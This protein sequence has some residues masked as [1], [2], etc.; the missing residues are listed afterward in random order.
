VDVPAPETVLHATC[1]ADAEGRGL[2]IL[3]PSGSGKSGLALRMMAL[4]ARLVADDRTII[5]DAGDHVEASCPAA[6][7][8]LI[9][10]RGVG[11]LR[12]Q[13]LRSARVV[14]AVDLA[15]RETVRLPE[16]RRIVFLGHEVDLVHGPVTAHFPAAL[17]LYLAEG[18]QE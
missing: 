10:A 17:M 1:V 12:A 15:A 9:E 11:L 14:L 6:T 16:R 18:R 2:L 7:R 8:G 4:G 5:R 13:V 3:G